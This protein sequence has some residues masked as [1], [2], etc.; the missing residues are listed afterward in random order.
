MS[1]SEKKVED[2][3]NPD[4][5]IPKDSPWG[6]LID[7]LVERKKKFDDE[8]GELLA[9]H[10]FAFPLQV[11]K[12]LVSGVREQ[13]N[14]KVGRLVRIRPVNDE[15]TYLGLYLGDLVRDVVALQGEKSK[16][17][18]LDARRN[19]AVYVFDL[20][21]IVFGDSSWW[22][23]IENEEQLNKVITDKDIEGTWYVKL[24][25]ELSKKKEAEK[26][27]AEEDHPGEPGEAEGEGSVR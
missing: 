5:S 3:R 15:K 19:P 22:A 21:Q 20:E 7:E 24:L 1:D 4:G 17:L 26:H 11:S 6:K 13:K 16:V 2:V 25:R 14:S 12:I 27:E 10:Q 18:F 8:H 9:S 23:F